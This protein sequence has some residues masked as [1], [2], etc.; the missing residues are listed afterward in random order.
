[1]GGKDVRSELNR[2]SESIDTM[3]TEF[4]S[5]KESLNAVTDSNTA[6]STSLKGLVSR[7]EQFDQ[8]L[9]QKD[10]EYKKLKKD[11]DMLAD[12]VIYM[13]AYSRRDN[14]IFDGVEEA[15]IGKR[16]SNDDC[17]N[18][19]RAIMIEKME[20]TQAVDFKI[21]RC[22]RLGA[23]PQPGKTAARPRGIIIKF[24]WFSDRQAVWDAR[25]KLKES[26]IYVKEDFPREILNRRQTLTPIMQ[27]AWRNDCVAYITVDK[28][29]II[30][31]DKKHLVFDVNSLDKLPHYC[32][33]KYA[34]TRK[35]E[36]TMV[37]FNAP[38]PLSNFHKCSLTIEGQE[39]HSTEQFY[40]FKKAELAGDQVT[41][42]KILK[43]D[44]A[45]QCKAFGDGVKINSSVW[46]KNNVA[47]MKQ[48]LNAKF[49]Q[50]EQLKD[51]LMCTGELHLAEASQ[52]DKFWG[53][54][55]GLKH[56]NVLHRQHWA[57][58]NMLGTLLM[59]LRS[60]FA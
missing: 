45:A 32:D 22:H 33:P 36:D 37:F 4:N 31:K 57:G 34:T 56:K 60:S 27:A 9:Q 24:H 25:K 18:K 11:Y 53:I 1:M 47:F 48:A 16:E 21:V 12:R 38:C 13:E 10:L 50:N 23:P 7:L 3:R 43:A 5:F 41:M 44:T 26:D 46:H 42:T 15:P 35:S 58:K 20:I 19:I 49:T 2:L 14:L 8:R 28:L 55:I 52:R 59:E 54:G 40:Q 29:H 39:Y 6:V 30:D 51:Y 17:L